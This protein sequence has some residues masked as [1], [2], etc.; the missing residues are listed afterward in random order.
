[1]P[2]K[3]RSTGKGGGASSRRSPRP[4]VDGSRLATIIHIMNVDTVNQFFDKIVKAV[5][6]WRKLFNR[7]G[8]LVFVHEGIGVCL[9]SSRE[10][11]GF[12]SSRVN[13]R[14]CRK[15]R[16]RIVPQGYRLLQPTHKE[17]FVVSP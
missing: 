14:Y 9:V 5:L 3:N 16:N 1:M 7:L 17:A 13:L 6:P 15:L 2:G 10:L 12:L 8:Q 11:N 4:A